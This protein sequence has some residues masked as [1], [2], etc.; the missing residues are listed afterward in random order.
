MLQLISSFAAIFSPNFWVFTTMRFFIGT[1]T[2][3]IMIVAFILIMELTG[4]GKREMVTSLIS[5]PLSIGEM[6][7]PLFAYYLRS[8]NTFSLG[9]ALPNLVFLVYFFVV[10]ESP[11]WLISTGQLDKASVIMANVAKR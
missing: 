5:V 10:P 3:G 1:S 4:P 9:I 11:K 7:M 8:W 6:I 2:A